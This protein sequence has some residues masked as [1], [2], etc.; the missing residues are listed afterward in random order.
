MTKKACVQC[1]EGSVFDLNKYTCVSYTSTNTNTNTNTNTSSN[2]SLPYVNC[3]NS[4]WNGQQ[5]V[6]CYLPNYWNE[7]LKVCETC[8]SGQ[9]Y[10]VA[11]R[12]CLACPNNQVFN[13]TSYT[14]VTAITS[15]NTTSSSNGNCPSTAPFWDGNNCVTCYLPNYWNHDTNRCES[16][17]SGQH[18]DVSEKK[19]LACPQNETFNF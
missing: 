19:C 11:A 8:P 15:T 5:C 10:D 2:S 13:F 12:R 16:C 9:H 3:T 4:F 18:Y 14:C 7:N 17:P 6:N 1:P